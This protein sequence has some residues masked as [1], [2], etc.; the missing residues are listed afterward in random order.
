[1][2]HWLDLAV[3]QAVGVRAVVDVDALGLQVLVDAVEAEP[4]AGALHVAVV[5]H[6]PERVR[7][8]H[9]GADAGLGALGKRVG[10]EAD[11]GLRGR[12]RLGQGSAGTAQ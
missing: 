10:L 8:G 11:I 6:C 5:G 1:M 7:P 9:E 12:Q 3:D 2:K 4:V